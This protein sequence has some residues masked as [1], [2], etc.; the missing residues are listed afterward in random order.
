MMNIVFK[1]SKWIWSYLGR[2]YNNYLVSYKV[3]VTE[4]CPMHSIGF[5]TSS[6]FVLLLQVQQEKSMS[7]VFSML[8]K[9]WA[10]SSLYIWSSDRFSG[11]VVKWCLMSSDVKWHIRHKLWPMP[12][13]GSINLYV[14]GNQKAREDGQLMNYNLMGSYRHYLSRRSFCQIEKVCES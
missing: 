12:K 2:N 1:G 7:F 9:F 13:H 5:L 11:Q 10:H 14:H 3:M 6:E 4:F 8:Q